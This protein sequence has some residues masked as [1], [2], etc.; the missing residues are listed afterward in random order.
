MTRFAT[1]TQAALGAELAADQQAAAQSLA[2][3]VEEARPYP[4]TPPPPPHPPPP[5]PT[6]PPPP[7]PPPHTPPP[8]P[9]SLP[10][11]LGHPCAHPSSRRG[12]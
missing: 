5:P 12:V 1:L 8:P 4:R 3:M 2:P 9:K 7:P 11:I 6:P 10:P